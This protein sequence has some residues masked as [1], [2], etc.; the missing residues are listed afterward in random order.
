[1]ALLE[2]ITINDGSVDDTEEIILSYKEMFEKEN[3]DGVIISS[4]DFLHEEQAVYALEHKVA[5]YL[6][7]PMAL[8]T[9]CWITQR[10]TATTISM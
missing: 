4:P 5:V 10:M 1:M 6:E 3:L 2:I 7:K 8:T 9:L